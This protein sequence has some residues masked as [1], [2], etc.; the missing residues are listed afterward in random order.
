MSRWISNSKRRIQKA[1]ERN[2]IKH[3]SSMMMMTD[4]DPLDHHQ[5]HQQLT[6]SNHHHHHRRRRNI[7][8]GKK[9]HMSF[10]LLLLC[11]FK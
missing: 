9:T 11:I 7:V 3:Q 1:T 2:L 4:D 8:E 5:Q 6:Y 10:P